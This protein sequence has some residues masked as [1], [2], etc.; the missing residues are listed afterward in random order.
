M[1]LAATV[2]LLKKDYYVVMLCRSEQRGEEA[3]KKAKEQSNRDHVELMLCDLCS[4]HSIRQ[5]AEAFYERFSKLDALINN[6]GIVTTKRTTTSDGFESMIGI[7]HLGHFLLTNLLLEKIKRSE[8]GR[9]VTI[10]SGA[11]KAGKIHF[12]D[13]HLKNNFSVIKG[14]GQSKL[15]NI[16]FTIQLDELL[17]DT[18]IQANS[19]HP[20]AVS[21]SLGI[22]R[23]TGFGKTIHS[24]LRP[25]FQTP[26]QGADTAVYLATFPELE[27]SGEYFYKR[28][29][30]ERSKLAQDKTLAE[31]LWEWS[32][33]EIALKD[34][35]LFQKLKNS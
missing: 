20:G 4:L 35:K 21:T 3:L 12:D 26:E 24:V 11:H 28:K 1:G 19:V 25:F 5:F 23:D 27:V 31:N 7:N 17:Q 15:S 2:E 32:E 30:A 33:R 8:Q 29:I 9:I 10:S 13:P 6:A 22:N 18:S 34:K 14:Y 16:L